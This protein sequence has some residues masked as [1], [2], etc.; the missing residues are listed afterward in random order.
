MI[1]ERKNFEI[2]K[3]VGISPRI[4]EK[5][6]R[7]IAMFISWLVS[8]LYEFFKEQLGSKYVKFRQILNM[9]ITM[10]KAG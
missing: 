5:W 9:K 6:S 2:Q 7:T 3:T 8:S 10:H 1:S 4:V